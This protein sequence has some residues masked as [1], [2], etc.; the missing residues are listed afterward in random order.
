MKIIRISIQQKIALEK[1]SAT[2]I[3]CLAASCMRF[4]LGCFFVTAAGRRS[5]LF[6][7]CVEGRTFE[8]VFKDDDLDDEA[9]ARVRGSGGFFVEAEGTLTDADVWRELAVVKRKEVSLGAAAAEV[10][11]VKL[12]LEDVR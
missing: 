9:R 8:G 2:K 4:H 10:V 3:N 7:G 11:D 12:P 6:G 5:R 1:V